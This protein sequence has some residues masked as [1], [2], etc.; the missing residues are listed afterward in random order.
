MSPSRD[1]FLI[2]VIPVLANNIVLFQPAKIDNSKGMPE[3]NDPQKISLTIEQL[4][5]QPHRNSN[6]YYSSEEYGFR[7]VYPSNWTIT[8]EMD[9]SNFINDTRQFG[10]IVFRLTLHPNSTYSEP[11]YDSSGSYS[12]S[13]YPV[14]VIPGIEISVIPQ[15]L[16]KIINNTSIDDLNQFT[17][18][19]YR[20]LRTTPGIELA[21]VDKTTISGQPAFKFAFTTTQNGLKLGDG[22]IGNESTESQDKVAKNKTT[23]DT[24]LDVNRIR[25]ESS[26]FPMEKDVFATIYYVAHNHNIYAILFKTEKANP[27][28]GMADFSTILSSFH[29]QQT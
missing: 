15:Y 4:P 25:N 27:E 18:N 22:N 17:L 16:P 8:S 20:L 1:I 14:K 12:I 23:V 29:V 13:Y 6:V 2:L 26:T 21:Q 10:P 11:H 5:T 7:F 28:F 9:Y 19:E 3:F 24:T